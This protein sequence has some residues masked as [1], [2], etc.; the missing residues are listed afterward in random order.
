MANPYSYITLNQMVTMLL[1]RLQDTGGVFTTA[2]EAAIHITEALRV[3]NAQTAVWNADYQ[4]GFAPNSSWQSINLAG[5]PRV[6]TITDA[7]IYTEMEYMLLE[8][9]TGGTWTGTD[10]F[11]ISSLSNPLQTRMNELLMASGANP[12]RNHSIPSTINLTTQLPDSV[13]ELRRVRWVPTGDTPY[14]LARDEA[15]MADAYN[16]ARATISGYPNSYMVTATQPLVF[17]TDIKPNVA[18]TW[19]LIA[20]ESGGVFAPPVATLMTLPNDWCWVAKYGALADVLENSPEG[21]DPARAKYCRARYDQGMKAMKALP[22]LLDASVA[23]ISVD[24]PSVSEMDTYA[25]NW[26]QNWASD[27][28]QIV[29]GGMD[30]VAL[31]PFN[32]TG[33]G[34]TVDSILTVVGNA[35]VPTVGAD[36]IQ[37]SRD[38]LE[39]VLNYAQ[40][41][42]T[43]KRGQE[44]FVATTTLMSQFEAY[45]AYVNRRYAALGVLRMDMIQEGRR[46]E[47]L[48]PREL[49]REELQKESKGDKSGAK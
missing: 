39:A 27:D 45:C 40:H 43:F 37:L 47:D 3:L 28:P 15:I 32:P 8:P 6:R 23:G 38:G 21:L 4:V 35:L 2:Q 31:A 33:S 11:N 9:P 18:G 44:E 17:Q 36:E 12:V 16:A 22:W 14:A 49:P 25:Q 34:A 48:N 10:Q 29:V 5:S 46:D 26:E 30:L 24:T 7:S 13:L 19:D 20:I 1:G 41:V 42:A